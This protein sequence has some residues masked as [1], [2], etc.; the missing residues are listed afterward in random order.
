MSMMKSALLFYCKFVA[1]L[2]SLGFDINPYDPCVTNKI[3]NGKQITICWHVDDLL[4]GHVNPAVVTNFLTWLATRYDTAEKK[5]NIV[6]GTKHNY[7]GMNMDFSSPGEVKFDMITY[8]NKFIST[9]PKKRLQL[10]G[11]NLLLLAI[12]SFKCALS[13]LRHNSYRKIWHGHFIIPLLNY[14]SFLGSDGIF[15]PLLLSCLLVSNVQMRM[16]GAN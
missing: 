5:L 13:L 11:C 10:Q 12:V 2:T 9:F 3:I 8:I 4:I 6:R 14:S 16:I 7:L 1:N 15:K